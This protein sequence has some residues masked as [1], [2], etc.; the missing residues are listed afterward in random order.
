MH[1][2]WFYMLDCPTWMKNYNAYSGKLRGSEGIICSYLHYRWLRL[3]NKR[4]TVSEL[5]R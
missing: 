5:A 4:T 2:L 1:H 3:S